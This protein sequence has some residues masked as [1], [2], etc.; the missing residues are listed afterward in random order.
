[1]EDDILPEEI[2]SCTTTGASFVISA[3]FQG[4]RSEGILT[5]QLFIY[6]TEGKGG[7]Q[8]LKSATLADN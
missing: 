8:A 6:N 5:H 2:R 4:K 1:M 3:H 7:R